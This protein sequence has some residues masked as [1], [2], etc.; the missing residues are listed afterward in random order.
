MTSS[1]CP[2]SLSRH[3]LLR[4]GPYRDKKTYD[5]LIPDESGFVSITESDEHPAKAGFSIVDIVADMYSWSN[6]LAASFQHVPERY[7]DMLSLKVWLSGQPSRCT[8]R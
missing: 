6:V 4:D 2:R 5:L 7:M 3:G 1:V 8:T